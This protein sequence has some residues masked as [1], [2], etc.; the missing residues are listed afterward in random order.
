MKPTRRRRRP[1]LILS[2]LYDGEIM[3]V[4][5]FFMVMLVPKR[6]KPANHLC[7]VCPVVLYGFVGSR[8]QKTCQTSLE[9]LLWFFMLALVLNS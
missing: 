2:E 5:W 3:Y 4:L 8:T 6:G 1:A 9:F 7:I